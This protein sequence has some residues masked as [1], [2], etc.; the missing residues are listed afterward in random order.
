MKV[1]KY[2]QLKGS[3]KYPKEGSLCKINRKTLIYIH[4]NTYY[5]YNI[6]EK[7]EIFTK[8]YI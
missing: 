4:N 8:Y 2:I 7:W 1:N 3:V 6:Y 5:Y